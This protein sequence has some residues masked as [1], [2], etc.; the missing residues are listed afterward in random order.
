[1]VFMGGAVLA[2]LMRDNEVEDFIIYIRIFVFKEFW[3]TRAEYE[4]K[5]VTHC[6]ER[7]KFR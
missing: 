4:E 1:M 6:M 5:G 3:V 7:L 2:N